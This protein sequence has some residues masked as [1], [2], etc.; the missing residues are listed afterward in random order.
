MLRRDMRPVLVTEAE[1]E[2]QDVAVWEWQAQ[3]L[4]R[5]GLSWLTA[6][7]FAQLADWHE[8]AELVERGCPAELALEIVR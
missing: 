8:V 3:Q 4:H 6:C 7:T 1:R 5:L 2:Q